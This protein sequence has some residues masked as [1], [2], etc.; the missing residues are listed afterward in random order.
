M[1][2]LSHSE[3]FWS[4]CV[5]LTLRPG[6]WVQAAH[7]FAARRRNAAPL[8]RLNIDADRLAERLAVKR[9]AAIGRG[10]AG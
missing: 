4:C 2:R 3:R 5:R 6:Q 1:T 7:D 8:R 10:E 9:A